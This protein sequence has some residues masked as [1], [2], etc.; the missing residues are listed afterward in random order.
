MAAPDIL[1]LTEAD[2][3]SLINLSGVIEALERALRLEHEGKAK[4]MYK[5]QTVWPQ[6]STNVTG[7]QFVGDGFSGAKVWTNVGGSSEP[8]TILHGADDG[9]VRALIESIALG[10]MRT[11][12]LAGVATKWLAAPGADELALVGSGKQS[13]TQVAAVHAVRPLKRLRVWS[14]RA[15]N[16]AKFVELARSRFSFEVVDCPTL[17][18]CVAGAPIVSTVTRAKEPF[19]FL[20]HLAPGAHLNA[21]GAIIPAFAEVDREVVAAADRIVV[22]NIEQVRENSRELRSELGDDSARWR[23]VLPLSAVVAEGKGRPKGAKLTLFKFMG[24][25]LGDLAAGIEI[26]RRALAQGKGRPLP[27]ATRVPVDLS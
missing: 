10:T 14:P 16:R 4:N 20:R 3:V 5:A 7:A 18:A 12:A 27:H 15:E 17:E 1:W 21:V 11:A 22:D 6:G 2:V 8:L 13:V 19:L 25:G 23:S 26:Y 9:K 24:V